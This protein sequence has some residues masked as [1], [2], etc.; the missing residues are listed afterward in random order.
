MIEY[1]DKSHW[2]K[3]YYR[4]MQ[5]RRNKAFGQRIKE[6]MDIYSEYDRNYHNGIPMH[7]H[8]NIVDT[9]RHIR[10]LFFF[11]CIADCNIKN[12]FQEIDYKQQ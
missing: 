7:E 12:I 10:Y 3:W 4:A 9:L 6:L 8:L 11:K 5:H 2:W 1:Q